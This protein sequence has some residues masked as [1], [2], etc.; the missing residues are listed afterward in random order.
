MDVCVC[1]THLYVIDSSL[2]HILVASGP[3]LSRRI[4]IWKWWH[5]GFDSLGIF[6]LLILGCQVQGLIIGTLTGVDSRIHAHTV[7]R[8]SKSQAS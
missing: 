1:P 5:K 8:R 3:N 2:E 4:S 7:G 6:P